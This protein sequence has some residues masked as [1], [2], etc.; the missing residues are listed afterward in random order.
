[1]IASPLLQL[2]EQLAIKFILNIFGFDT[3]HK[4]LEFPAQ[5]G[6]CLNLVP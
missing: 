2:L 3:V 4:Q 5:Q 1:M 6:K